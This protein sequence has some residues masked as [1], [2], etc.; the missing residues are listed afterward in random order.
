M[1]PSPVSSVQIQTVPAVRRSWSTPV[2]RG[3]VKVFGHVL[4][5]CLGTLFAVV[6]QAVLSG[7]AQSAV[8][9]EDA[10]ETDAV[11]AV[12]AALPASSGDSVESLVLDEACSL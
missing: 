2:L 7:F 4:A 1:S 6:I 8:L 5:W 12:S 10:A 9:P 3:S 11:P